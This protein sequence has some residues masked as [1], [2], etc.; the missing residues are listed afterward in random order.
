MNLETAKFR[1]EVMTLYLE[2]VIGMG[3]IGDEVV[4]NIGKCQTK[5]QELYQKKDIMPWLS[6]Q[7]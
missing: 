5:V 6:M 2:V 1:T 3:A 4:E 7:N